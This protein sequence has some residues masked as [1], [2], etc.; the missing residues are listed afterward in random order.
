MS[1][2]GGFDSLNFHYADTTPRGVGLAFDNFYTSSLPPSGIPTLGEWA[3]IVFAV[4]ILGMMTYVFVRRR[5]GIRPTA[6]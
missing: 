3:L 6:A 1:V 4:V 2:P 5:R